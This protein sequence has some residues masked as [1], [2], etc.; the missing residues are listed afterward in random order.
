MAYYL[1][2]DGGGSKTTA[3]VC[4]ENLNKISSFVGEGINFNS[5]GMQTARQNLKGVVEGVLAG[6]D[7]SLNAAFIGMSAI[8]N[9]ADKELTGELCGGIINCPN[10]TM[11]SDVFIALEA[12][13]CDGPAAMVIS[14]TGSMACGRLP[15]GSIIHTGGWG[16]ILG[17]EGSGYGM[18]LDAVKSAIRAY[19][20]SGPATALTQGVLNYCKITDMQEIIDIFYN[21]PMPRSE[22]AKF[23]PVFLEY[24][25]S[26]DEVAFNILK[27]HAKELAD[28]VIALLKQMPEGT[29]LGL[30]G[31][32]MENSSEFREE[33]TA[34]IK[35]KFPKTE[36]N[37]LKYPPEY[38]AVMAAIKSDK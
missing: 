22:I 6:K 30:W 24:V 21:P 31:G 12:M 3:I 37:L 18:A 11:D 20:K 28:T 14:G 10:I 27:K 36:V 16:Y 13:G 2:I 38:G 23:A 8:S 1:G 26:G 17:D 29:P 33:F 19:E 35:D 9:R 25:N 7:I 15:D 34:Q 32:I 4:D 5:I